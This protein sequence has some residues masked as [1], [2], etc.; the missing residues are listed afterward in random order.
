[1]KTQLF[2]GLPP[3]AM[4]VRQT[5]FVEEQGF[6]DEFDAIDAVAAHIV[7]FDEGVPVGVC[8]VFQDGESYVLGR[9]AVVKEY[10][11]K[12]LGSRLVQGAEHYVQS[13]GGEELRLHAQCRAA[14]FYGKLGYKEFGEVGYEENCP[15][16]W[17]KKE[18]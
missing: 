1:M 18:L 3:Q 9:L 4:Q 8:R 5:V 12:G 10:R 17:M 6:R 15:H 13:Q 11:S 2:F 14:E 16:I 7:L